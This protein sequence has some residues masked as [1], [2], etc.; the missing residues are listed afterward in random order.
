MAVSEKCVRKSFERRFQKKLLKEF[1]QKLFGGTVS[2]KVFRKVCTETF[3]WN[4]FRKSCWKSLYEKVLHNRFR[5]VFLMVSFFSTTVSEKCVQ[6][7]FHNRFRKS[8][9]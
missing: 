2:E 6:K 3:W 9:S 4:R 8:F 7:L 1:V 5:K